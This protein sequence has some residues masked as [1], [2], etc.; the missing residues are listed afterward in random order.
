ML[1]DPLGV[2]V[3][4]IDRHIQRFGDSPLT[5]KIRVSSEVAKRL[6]QSGIVAQVIEIDD[7]V[8]SHAEVT[9]SLPFVAPQEYR[10]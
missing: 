3:R 6:P 4:E 5:L 7:S 2:I 10:P 8:Q 9:Y 1:V